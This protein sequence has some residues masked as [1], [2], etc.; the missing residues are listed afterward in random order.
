MPK[1]RTSITIDK[2]LLAKAK[3]YHISISSFLDIELRRY[4]A[5]LE[6][7]NSSNRG[8]TDERD[9]TSSSYSNPRGDEGNS[10]PSQGLKKIYTSSSSKEGPWGSLVS[11]WLRE[12]LT[13][14][15]IPAGPFLRAF[16]VAK[17]SVYPLFSLAS[18]TCLAISY[19]SLDISRIFQ[20]KSL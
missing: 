18:D 14:V 15:Q 16:I 10:H 5:M 20:G 2:D 8:K 3:K 4:I 7:S 9:N 1:V 12:P 19:V 6:L 17:I 13:R 11:L